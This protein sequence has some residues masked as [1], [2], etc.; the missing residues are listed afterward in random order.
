LPSGSPLIIRPP[1]QDPHH[2]AT[3]ASIVG[4]GSGSGVAKPGAAS[5]AHKGVLFLDLAPRFS[6][7]GS[8]VV[9][10]RVRFGSTPPGQD[11]RITGETSAL[12]V[13]YADGSD[14]RR[15]TSWG[16]RAGDADWSPDGTSI[17][18]ETNFTHLGNG[19]SV[20]VVR[21]DGSGLENLTDDHG[22]TGVGRFEALRFEHS[23]DPAWSPDG[24]RIVFGHG[25][26]A[27]GAFTEGLMAM[28]PDGSGRAY[29]SPDVAAEHQADWG[30]A[31]L[32]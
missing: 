1:F 28:A 16:I 22:T 5:L 32:R 15:V 2:T 10:T 13:V 27:D 8:R 19:P 29:V 17:V 7:D 23:F 18:F 20:Y 31:P 21:P 25:R 30:T 26:L 11:W 9:F 6:P 4:G 24:Q 12:F 3:T 14:L